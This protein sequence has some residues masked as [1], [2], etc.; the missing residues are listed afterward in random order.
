M[1]V[2]VMSLFQARECTNRIVRGANRGGPPPIVQNKKIT[3]S[4]KGSNPRRYKRCGVCEGCKVTFSSQTFPPE[5]PMVTAFFMAELSV[6][7][8][9]EGIRNFIKCTS[10]NPS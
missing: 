10:M 4:K 9:E 5:F 1:K 2:I 3:T 6:H 7:C 8:I